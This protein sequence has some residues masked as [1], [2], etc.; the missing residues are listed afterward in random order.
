MKTRNVENERFF[1][2]FLNRR[3][4]NKW[5]CTLVTLA[6]ERAQLKVYHENNCFGNWS[7]SLSD[8]KCMN[9]RSKFDIPLEKLLLWCLWDVIINF[10]SF[11]LFIFVSFLIY[12][13]Q[14]LWFVLQRSQCLGD[15]NLHRNSN[16][17]LSFIIC[18]WMGKEI[19]KKSKTKL[20]LK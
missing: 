20:K 4:I 18:D 10:I 7:S 17:L 12:L 5:K 9:R 1:F 8:L 14:V 11:W 16:F 3:I 13:R 2:L 15:H 19:R 6:R